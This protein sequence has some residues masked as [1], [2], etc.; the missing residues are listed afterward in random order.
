MGD[1][2]LD[3]FAFKACLGSGSFGIVFGGEESH[4]HRPVAIK[5]VCKHSNLNDKDMLSLEREADFCQNLPCHE[6]VVSVLGM[7]ER[8]FEA[9][10][11]EELWESSLLSNKEQHAIRD[12]LIGKG[13]FSLEVNINWSRISNLSHFALM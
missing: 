11:L 4:T 13:F 3:N 1:L 10:E 6:N 5:F 2:F 7:S 8:S 12:T 9:Q